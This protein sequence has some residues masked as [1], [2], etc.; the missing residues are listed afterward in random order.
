MKGYLVNEEGL[1]CKLL[2]KDLNVLVMNRTGVVVDT[3]I[4]WYP[5][6]AE[7]SEDLLFKRYP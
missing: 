7:E 3:I 2:L 6:E 5:H 1:S 4:L